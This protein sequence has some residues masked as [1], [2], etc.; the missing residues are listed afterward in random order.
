MSSS[1]FEHRVTVNFAGVPVVLVFNQ[2]TGQL[3]VSAGAVTAD[4]AIAQENQTSSSAPAIAPEAANAGPGTNASATEDSAE[5]GDRLTIMSSTPECLRRTTGPST[6]SVS[7][8]VPIRTSQARCERAVLIGESASKPAIT[9]ET[10]NVPVIA[11]RLPQEKYWVIFKSSPSA[12]GG[13]DLRGY[14]T[15]KG[16]LQVLLGHPLTVGSVFCGFASLE[17]A[18]AAWRAA[19]LANVPCLCKD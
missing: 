4:I 2:R 8:E 1:S 3:T 11:G 14:V 17:E 5:E 19:G 7:S 10:L 12:P 6:P 9:Q 13:S 18:H 16:R 15:S